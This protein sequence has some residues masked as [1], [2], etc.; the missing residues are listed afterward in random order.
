MKTN[1]A[2]H[3]NHPAEDYLSDGELRPE[4]VR[5]RL[6]RCPNSEPTKGPGWYELEISVLDRDYTFR[7]SVCDAMRAAGFAVHLGDRGGQDILVR[8][9][10]Y[11]APRQ[12]T[13]IADL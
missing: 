2:T 12:F 3:D 1:T 11:R 13:I 8:R 7:R 4:C 9:V 10:N 5:V 6:T